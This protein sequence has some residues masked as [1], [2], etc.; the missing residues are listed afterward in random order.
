MFFRGFDQ[1][2]ADTYLYNEWQRDVAVNGLSN[3]TLPE[4]SFAANR[5]QRLR[6]R[7]SRG[8]HVDAHRSFG[9]VIS[10]TAGAA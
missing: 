2:N 4:H 9:Y 3:L 8:D 7:Q 10:P 6:D 5:R 1:N